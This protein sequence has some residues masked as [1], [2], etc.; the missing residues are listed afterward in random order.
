MEE[1]LYNLLQERQKSAVVH[2]DAS[3]EEREELAHLRGIQVRRADN[4]K[5][6]DREAGMREKSGQRRRREGSGVKGWHILEP[7]SFRLVLKVPMAARQQRRKEQSRRDAAL[8]WGSRLS[9]SSIESSALANTASMVTFSAE[10]DRSRRLASRGGRDDC[11][12]K[13]RL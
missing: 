4:K 2:P 10:L 6:S 8:A 7:P 13:G 9:D 3:A 12:G 5:S 11:S 1:D